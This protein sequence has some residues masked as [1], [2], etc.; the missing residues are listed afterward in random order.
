MAADSFVLV[1]GE[2]VRI[3]KTSAEK[4]VKLGFRMHWARHH[5]VAYPYMPSHAN[6]I[7]SQRIE[8]QKKVV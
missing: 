1:S 5:E 2:G 6:S 8:M 3:A 4:D 7:T